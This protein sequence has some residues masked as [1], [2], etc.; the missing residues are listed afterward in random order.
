MQ[1]RL[2]NAVTAAT[3]ISLMA[4][5]GANAGCPSVRVLSVTKVVAR[6]HDATLAAAAPSGV[7][8]SLVI[9][10][11]SGPSAARGLVA[12][13]AVKGRVSWTWTVS[14]STTAGRWPIYVE[15]GEAGIAKTWFRVAA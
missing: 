1:R 14:R 8:C 5:L 11:R 15:C 12:K 2:R 9:Y 10:L 4:A 6:D 3:L 7:R 13:R